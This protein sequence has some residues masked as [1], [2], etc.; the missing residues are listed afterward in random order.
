MA[1]GGRYHHVGR[2]EKD[3]RDANK[4][5]D[6]ACKRQNIPFNGL[7][8]KTHQNGLN[9]N[10]LEPSTQLFEETVS[11]TNFIFCQDFL[12]ANAACFHLHLILLL[13]ILLSVK[14]AGKPI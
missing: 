9:W 6:K 4:R 5:L 8:T 12:V 2:R 14:A 3:A 13:L 1:A 11:G 7:G 10:V